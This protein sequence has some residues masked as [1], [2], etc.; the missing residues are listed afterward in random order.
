MQMQAEQA[1]QDM[2]D[3]VSHHGATTR[4]A[5]EFFSGEGF[6]LSE[7]SPDVTRAHFVDLQDGELRLVIRD[8][9]PDRS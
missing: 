4:G 7:D 6:R 5:A 8:A 1:V 9:S 3:Q 2:L